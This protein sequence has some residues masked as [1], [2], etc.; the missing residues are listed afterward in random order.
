MF[1]LKNPLFDGAMT[2]HE[3][4]CIIFRK[5]LEKGF[6]RDP[7]RIDEA[8]EVS[9]SNALLKGSYST[10]LVPLYLILYHV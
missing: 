8:A 5:E 6:L 3:P 2:V 1:A 10:I 9:R 7:D 4:N